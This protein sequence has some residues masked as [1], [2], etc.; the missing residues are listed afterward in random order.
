MS[1]TTNESKFTPGPYGLWKVE[2]SGLLV[3]KEGTTDVV[4]IANGSIEGAWDGDA[5]AEANA[6]L[7]R[8][9]PALLDAA[10]RIAASFDPNALYRITSAADIAAL[11]AA[12]AAARG[13]S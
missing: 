5:E 8:A 10:E 4:P 12:I 1:D 6:Y 7:W 9:A 13:A 2:G 11:R 3:V